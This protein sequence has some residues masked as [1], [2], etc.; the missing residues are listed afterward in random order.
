MFGRI[1]TGAFARS[2]W[3]LVNWLNYTLDKYC[4]T[5]ETRDALARYWILQD[6]K[7]IFPTHCRYL[8]YQSYLLTG[9]PCIV[10]PKQQLLPDVIK[11]V[12]PLGFCRA[13]K[14]PRKEVQEEDPKLGTQLTNGHAAVESA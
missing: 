3:E 6:P 9:E 11:D 7:R 1:A 2:A 8:T 12:L 14:P 4:R 10:V 13:I 5:D